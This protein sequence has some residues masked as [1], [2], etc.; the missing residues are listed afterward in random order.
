MGGGGGGTGDPPCFPPKKADV[1]NSEFLEFDSKCH[2][3]RTGSSKD[4]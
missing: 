1:E 2:I 3:N 4:E